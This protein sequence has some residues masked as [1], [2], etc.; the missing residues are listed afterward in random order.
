M[1]LKLKPLNMFFMRSKEIGRKPVN[2]PVEVTFMT[3]GKKNKEEL[4]EVNKEKEI[5]AEEENV[6]V[7]E[8]NEENDEEIEKKMK[9]I[10][11]EENKEKKWYENFRA[12]RSLFSFWRSQKK[13][14]QEKKYAFSFFIIKEYF[15][16]GQHVKNDAI[17]LPGV[18]VYYHI[19]ERGYNPLLKYY[20]I[21]LTR[22]V[23]QHRLA[24]KLPIQ[25]QY[26]FGFDEDDDERLINFLEDEV[27]K[28]VLP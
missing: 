18:Y 6:E 25:T 17:D 20:F 14:P 1:K 12:G 24:A 5:L 15:T 27:M 28:M 9:K 16:E 7:E 22:A 21:D 4:R 11:E 23:S 10:F 19:K 2:K 3:D 26:N 13:P 8:K